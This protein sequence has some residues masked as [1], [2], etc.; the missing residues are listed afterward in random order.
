MPSFSS[1]LQF[2]ALCQTAHS[3]MLWQQQIVSSTD[4][5]PMTIY[6]F[7]EKPGLSQVEAE[8]MSQK[9]YD[10]GI[11]AHIQTESGD[12]ELDIC[13]D[14]KYLKARMSPYSLYDHEGNDLPY[15][16]ESYVD[17]GTYGEHGP[18]SLIRFYTSASH[19]NN[20]AKKEMEMSTNAFKFF[21]DPYVQK[22]TSRIC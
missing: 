17:W 16:L 7:A 20:D 3:H 1:I 6:T 8:R 9:A 19:V 22:R 15:A 18:P 12:S 11:K 5:R 14:G 21:F 2:I 4:S 10:K 13:L